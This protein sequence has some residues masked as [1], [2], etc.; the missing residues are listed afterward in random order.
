MFR[1]LALGIPLLL[2]AASCTYDNGDSRQSLYGN[3]N[4]NGSQAY[5]CNTPLQS[6][7]ETDQ[8]IVIDA[9]QG[10]GVFI[11]YASGG[12]YTLSTAC[13]TNLSNSTC[14]W[15]IIIDPQAGKML[16]NVMGQNLSGADSLQPYP[17]PTDSSMLTSYHLTAETT[18]E[19]DSVTFDTDPGASVSIDAYLDGTCALPFF[20]WFGD[21]ALHEGAPS[22]PVV[23]TPSSN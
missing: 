9:G 12:H 14:H 20:F 2:L 10:A 18:T 13:D 4:G 19:I 17:G 11:Q 6:T 23:L 5:S 15:D 22:N 3:G 8:Q 1:A 16:S 21:G 7:I